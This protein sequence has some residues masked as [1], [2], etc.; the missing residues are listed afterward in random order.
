MAD[1]NFTP[2]VVDLVQAMLLTAAGPLWQQLQQQQAAADR[3]GVHSRAARVCAAS[4][5]L[6][7]TLGPRRY[8]FTRA[9]LL[10]P[11]CDAG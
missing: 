7:F 1:P 8:S 2:M 10:P 9:A 3:C 11:L 5:G 4:A 6:G